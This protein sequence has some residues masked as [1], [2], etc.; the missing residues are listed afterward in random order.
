MLD[1]IIVEERPLKARVIPN[2]ARMFRSPIASITL[3]RRACG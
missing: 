3:A 2:A 1:L